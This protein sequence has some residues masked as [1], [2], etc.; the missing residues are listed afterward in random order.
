MEVLIYILPLLIAYILD[1]ILGDPRW[2]PHP[3]RLYGNFIYAGE[4]FLN[5]GDFR[6]AKGAL[7]TIILCFIAFLFFY[8]VNIFIKSYPILYVVFNSIFLFYALANRSLIQEGKAV[9]NELDK[10]ITQ[11]GKRLSWIVGRDTSQLNE[12]QIK[13]AVF[14]TLSENLSDGVIAPLFYYAILGVPGA[15]LYKMI[16]TLDSMIGYKNDRYLYFGKFAAKLDDVFNY[17]PSRITGIIM[18][19]VTG[20]VHKTTEMF[21]EGK[22]HSSPN[23]GYP[24]AALALILDCRFGGPNYYHG[25]LVD[26]PYIGYHDRIL[27]DSEFKTVAKINH[28]T[29]FICVVGILFLKLFLSL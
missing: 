20:K 9:F 26:K 1:L 18:L 23:A 6:F 10:G 11:G 14:E 25:K 4:R 17:I 27:D 5:K 16:N 24:E 12:Q 19:T 22:K 29:T 2:L 8:G 28:S 7:L 21:S 15:M 3:I 13:T